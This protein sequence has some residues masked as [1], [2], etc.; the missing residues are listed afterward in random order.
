[1]IISFNL[2]ISIYS[3][4]RNETPKLIFGKHRI[5][6]EFG[7]SYE[8]ESRRLFLILILTFKILSL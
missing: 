4:H 8:N 5:K 1:M 2:R 7:A 3:L 6:N